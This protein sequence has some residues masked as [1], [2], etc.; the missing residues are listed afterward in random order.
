MT[1]EDGTV[2]TVRGISV[3]GGSISIEAVDEKPIR[4][5]PDC[6]HVLIWGKGASEAADSISLP[7]SLIQKEP[8]LS[9]ITVPNEPDAEIVS[10][11]GQLPGIERTRLVRPVLGY[12]ATISEKKKVDRLD[13]MLRICK[14]EHLSL[15]E[16]AQQYEEDRSGFSRKRIRALMQRQLE[17]MRESDRHGLKEEFK[18]LY[19]LTSGMDGKRLMQVCETGK[20]ISGGLIPVATAKALGIMEYNASMG[21]IV[22]APTAGSAGIVPGCILTLQETFGFSDNEIVDAMFVS[23]IIG[24]VMAHREV[25]FSGA[26]GGCQGEVGVSSAIAAAGIASLFSNDPS[27]PVE[28][29]SM[30]MKNLLGLICDPIAGPVEVPCI[31]SNAVGVANAFISADMACAG[32]ESYLP[33]DQVID[34]LIDTERRLPF[35]LRGSTIGGLACAEKAKELREKLAKR[36]ELSK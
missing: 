26:V 20:S 11:F 35:E 5:K 1:A 10:A 30:C 16:F 36:K 14:E 18:M 7:H 25:S 12:G 22:A 27:V 15:A 24:V 8:G 17:V 29:M 34:A 2:V 3:G 32:I 19:G 23:A 28:A 6:Y 33:G 21:C 31:K 9:C 13:D 4:L